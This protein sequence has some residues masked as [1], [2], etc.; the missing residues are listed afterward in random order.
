METNTNPIPSGNDPTVRRYSFKIQFEDGSIENKWHEM[1]EADWRKYVDLMIALGAEVY[2]L[3][4][5]EK[6]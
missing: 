1:T 3:K 5:T 6:G 2:G 4:I